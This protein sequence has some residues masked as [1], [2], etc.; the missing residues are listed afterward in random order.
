MNRIRS[1]SKLMGIIILTF[2]LLF[3]GTSWVEAT[4]F[5][6]GQD[7]EAPHLRIHSIGVLYGTWKEMGI[8]YGERCAEDI[9]K[10]FDLA[11]RYNVLN[12]GRDN[13]SQRWQRTTRWPYRPQT[14]YA[15]YVRKYIARSH[16]ELKAL[17]PEIAE[18]FE[19]I[20]QGAKKEL[21]KSPYADVIE[22]ALKIQI[23]NW[24]NLAFHPNWDFDNDRPGP[25]P[26]AA[27]KS[28]EKSV[29]L[30]KLDER[31][32]DCNGI[33]IHGSATADGNTYA[34]RQAQG[35]S[36]RT[37][38][39]P[40]YNVIRSSGRERQISYVAISSD[41]KAGVFFAYGR[42]GNIGGGPGGGV[43]NEH[44]VG[45]GTSGCSY[46][47]E[48]WDNIDIT[49]APGARDF[50]LAAYGVIF[51]KTAR[52]AAER[53]T[54]GTKEYR[55]L[56]GRKTV[57]RARGA[58]ILFGDPDKAFVVESNARRYAIREP[59]F[60]WGAEDEKFIVHANHFN[61]T[62]GSYD[63]NNVFHADDPM[64]FY[65]DATPG[66]STY[67][68]FW[69]G[70]YWA[71]KNVGN[72]TKEKMLREIAPLHT[73]YDEDGNEFPPH[74]TGVPS[75]P[76]T[77]CAHSGVD[78]R[79]GT[80]NPKLRLGRGG[81]Q[82]STVFNLSQRVAWY[83]PVWPCH[84]KEWNMSWNFVDLKPY[85]NIRKAKGWYKNWD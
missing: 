9:A 66:S 63:E 30:A 56:T 78:W 27:I 3:L 52:E 23:L 48:S 65:E 59:G 10:N 79:T 68:R 74:D 15:E 8:Q 83:V 2:T 44:G 58:D 24:S 75:V 6:L 49:V 19:G 20:A 71:L 60:I 82:E 50:I 61:Y 34:F 39:A 13:G 26:P 1:F 28:A 51:S 37:D 32:H 21:E 43:L 45:V 85:I 5:K 64:T 38:G 54:I 25:G 42:A 40:D 22:G 31:G 57:L 41:P 77:F 84:Y 14:E 62:A 12:D 17:S 76:G 11:W 33:W 72:I 80:I 67:Y 73:A 4:D 55:R 7:Q 47:S 16:Q 81:G 46:S 29:M 35:T 53:I 18:F 36:I 70:M 69:S